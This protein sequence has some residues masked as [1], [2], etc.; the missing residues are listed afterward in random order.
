VGKTHRINAADHGAGESLMVADYIKNLRETNARRVRNLA[1]SAGW[2][3][4]QVNKLLKL[5]EPA[6]VNR[7]EGPDCYLADRRLIGREN[8]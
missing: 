2:S 5:F 6:L 8:V 1:A 3:E 7:F 4:A